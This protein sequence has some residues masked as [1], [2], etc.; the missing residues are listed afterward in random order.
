M[1]ARSMEPEFLR[2]SE[3]L[4]S[5]HS[6]ASALSSSAMQLVASLQ[7]TFGETTLTGENGL[8]SGAIRRLDTHLSGC[9]HHL[10]SFQAISTALDRLQ[11][12]ASSLAQLG[13]ALQSC[14]CSFLI[15]SA[16][17][18]EGRD[19][20][21]DFVD[22]LRMLATRIDTLGG[23]I[24]EHCVA[25]AAEQAR[26]TASFKTGFDR[27]Q[28]LSPA[29]MATVRDAS[30]R[31]DLLLK[32]S[33]ELLRTIEQRAQA[34][35]THAASAVYFLQSG[36]ILRQKLE[37]VAEALETA[38]RQSTA[39]PAPST[40]ANPNPPALAGAPLSQLLAVQR[41]QLE[42][43]SSEALAAH[44]RL[45]LAFEGLARETEGL[46][47]DMTTLASVDHGAAALQALGADV[48]QI[49]TLQHRA[50]D[51]AHESSATALRS[52]ELSKALQQHL[53]E[54]GNV[55]REL[56]LHALNAIIKT[57]W[58]GSAGASLG[59]LSSY[60]H[61][62][63]KESA[64][65]VEEILRSLTEMQQAAAALSGPSDAHETAAAA[66]APLNAAL[67]RIGMLDDDVRHTAVRADELA[68]NQRLQLENAS[69]HLAFLTR[70][71]DESRTPIQ[72]LADLRSTLP[73]P[74][75]A[76][77]DP[78]AAENAALV[79]AY[80]M[81][82]ERAVHRTVLGGAGTAVCPDPANSPADKPASKSDEDLGD[83]VD[84]F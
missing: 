26:L 58:L 63:S 2:L 16:R 68:A 11:R 50:E 66:D 21:G 19:S 77:G 74:P 75:R 49:G 62:L 14:G 45:T 48:Q 4:T 65:S 15:E 3:A 70:L 79:G 27:L 31:V 36:D 29:T 39:K 42:A 41:A 59:V 43:V 20:F 1:Q 35:G 81:E 38:A 53:D 84:L 67:Q 32:T 64:Q 52:A 57:A 61:D 22:N 30:E 28:S 76:S 54:V 78:Q 47:S 5:V 55:S 71:A 80:T 33:R 69:A 56:H 46:L 82:S 24:V 37:H 17:T 6:G 18:H 13:L 8:V 44:Q 83:N 23:T 40:D 10:S 9:S 72:L 73:E 60:V 12:Q 51:L 7:R 34:I 25:S